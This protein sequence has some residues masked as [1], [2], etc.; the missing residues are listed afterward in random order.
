MT[1]DLPSPSLTASA[2]P[3]LPTTLGLSNGRGLFG[4]RRQSASVDGALASDATAHE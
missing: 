2:L 3:S 1:A 4:V